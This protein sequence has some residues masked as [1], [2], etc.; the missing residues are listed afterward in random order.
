MFYLRKLWYFVFNVQDLK[1]EKSVF[2]VY[3]EGTAKKGPN[4]EKDYMQTYEYIQGIVSATFRL[5]KTGEVSLPSAKAYGGPVPIMKK[6]LDDISK[7][8][9]YIPE[10]YR[11][12]YE[13]RLAWP[14][15]NNSDNEED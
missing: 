10:Q 1:T 6:K 4:E 11:G 5:A 3:P 7:V 9:H 2:Y 14:T 12:F 8:T 13:E 15:G